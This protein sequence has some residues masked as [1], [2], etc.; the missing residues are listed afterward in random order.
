MNYF[1]DLCY[2]CVKRKSPRCHTCPDPGLESTLTSFSKGISSSS[3]TPDKQCPSKLWLKTQLQ[4]CFS[5]CL[6]DFRFLGVSWDPKQSNFSP[7]TNSLSFVRDS[8]SESCRVQ[9]NRLRA[10]SIRE[11]VGKKQINSRYLIK[12]KMFY[13][14]T[15]AIWQLRCLSQTVWQLFW[16][17]CFS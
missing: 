11:F 7:A 6:V 14:L 13:W 16:L 12:G 15:L 10:L 8:D 2:S 5:N 17:K 9:M 1:Y 3:S 4:D